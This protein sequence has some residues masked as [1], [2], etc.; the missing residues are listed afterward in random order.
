MDGTTQLLTLKVMRVSRPTLASAWEPFYSSSPSFSAHSTASVMSLQGKT[1]LEG[2]PKTLRD[3]T[4]ISEVLT[5]PSSFGAI[6]LGET[7][8]SCLSV[9]NEASV[10]IEAVALKVEMQTATTKTTLAEFGGPDDTLAVGDSLERVVSHEIK[11]LGQHVLGCTVS[12]RAPAGARAAPPGPAGDASDRNVLSFRKFYKFAVTNPLSVKTKVHTPRAPS[13]L[14]SR[15]EREKVFL[16]VH[17]QNLTQ[18][19]MWLEHMRFECTDGWQVEDTNV[20]DIDAGDNEGIFSG[21]MALMHPQDIRQYIYALSPTMLSPFPVTHPPGSIV[22]LGRLD[23]S[24]RSSFGEP[25][26]LLTSMLSRRIPLIQAPPQAPTVTQ[27][28]APVP[29]PKQ[30]PS[31]IP[32][33]M[34]RGA[35]LAGGA[36]PRPRSPQLNRP[37]SPPVNPAGVMPYRPGSPFRNRTIPASAGSQSPNTPVSPSPNFRHPEDVEVDL[38]VRNIPREALA[39]EKPFHAAFTVTASAP[40]PLARPGETRRQRVL[41]LIVQHAQPPRPPIA[42]SSVAGPAAAA[43]EA[44]SP[45][46]PSSGISTPSPS[47]TPY[48]GDFQD[49]LAQRLLVASPRR[50]NVD[51]DDHTSPDTAGGGDTPGPRADPSAVVLPPP[52]AN[53]M[54][55]E[56][57]K[58]QLQDVVHL[59]NSALFLPQLKL[60]APLDA[61]AHAHIEHALAHGRYSSNMSTD[62][63]ADSET[64]HTGGSAST[65]V[66]ASQDF[67]LTYLPLKSGF[68]KVGGLR[69]LLVEDRMIDEDVIGVDASAD[70]GPRRFNMEP[71]TLKEWDVVAEI[72]VSS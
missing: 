58:S 12:Y 7:F 23:I 22:P 45:R 68:L 52:I 69:I 63:E 49:T 27:A 36:P 1:P 15:A 24:W 19:V 30:A 46:L 29:P 50:T 51:G 39:V 38:V 18:E 72:W 10:D 55:G 35:S 59:G 8:S 37:T 21:S 57:P 47:G 6:Q 11:E 65:K 56:G 32:L 66:V 43:R 61:H 64:N 67:E 2:H 40:I 20:A 16:E 5:L 34:Q 26:R 54:L 13:A 3:L 71:R 44:W 14:L 31:A 9:N 33:H 25:G 41:S 48:R 62:S 70:G 60:V 17:I 53:V 4:H 28:P 42:S